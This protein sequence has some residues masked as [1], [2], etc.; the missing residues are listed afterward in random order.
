MENGNRIGKLEQKL[1]LLWGVWQ[2]KEI[3]T[4]DSLMEWN[5][6]KSMLRAYKKFRIKEGT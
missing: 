6:H 2:F 5:R 1:I 4:F 3:L